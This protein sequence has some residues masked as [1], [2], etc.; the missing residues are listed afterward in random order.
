MK[1]LTRAL[2]SGEGIVIIGVIGVIGPGL[3]SEMSGSLL[4][5]AVGAAIIVTG[6]V[7]EGIRWWRKRSR[8]ENPTDNERTG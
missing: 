8:I 2:L 7:I 1:K 4:W 6:L 5:F 3:S